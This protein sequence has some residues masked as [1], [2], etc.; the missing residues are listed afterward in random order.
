MLRIRI[1]SIQESR[2]TQQSR[3]WPDA[4][5]RAFAIK[6]RQLKSLCGLHQRTRRT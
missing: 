1:F 4:I 3:T 5:V 2:P 6:S